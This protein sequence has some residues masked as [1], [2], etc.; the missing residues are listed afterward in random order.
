[1]PNF[2]HGVAGIATALALAGA[3]LGRPDLTDAARLGAEHLVTLGDAS[4]GGFVVP[5]RI[6]PAEDQDEVT[7]TWCHGPAGTSLLFPALARAGVTKIAGQAPSRWHRRC[8]DSVRTSGVPNRLHPGFWDNDGRC[9]GT[10]GV[11][12]VFLDS[13]L[14]HGDDDDLEFGMRLADTLVDRAVHDGDH[15]YWRFIEHRAKDPLLPP[16]VGWMQGAAGIA[17]FLF[18][19]ARVANGDRATVARMDNWWALGRPA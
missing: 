17:A 6:P 3:E 15:A 11:G 2:S 12:E 1:M 9:C 14:R 10:A 18:R 4:A 8:L 5:R 7:Y 13:W 16:G 19:A